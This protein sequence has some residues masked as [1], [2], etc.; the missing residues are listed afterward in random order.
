MANFPNDADG[1]AL[2]QMANRGVDMGKPIG[3]EFY[4]HVDNEETAA[5]VLNALKAAGLGEGTEIV[6][7]EGELE[8]GEQMTK[9]NEEFWPSWTVYVYREL[10]PEYSGVIE[11]QRVLGA[12]ARPHGGRID[13]WG[14]WQR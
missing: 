13:G 7:D 9:E 6:Y 3:F 1:L 14:V 5:S 10:M 11:M 8:E 12:L 2:Q 4:I